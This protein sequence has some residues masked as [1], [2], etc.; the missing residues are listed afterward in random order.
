MDSH[1]IT[2][3]L[4]AARKFYT[5]EFLSKVSLIKNERLTESEIM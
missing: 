4:H 3:K 1:C 5:K 2:K